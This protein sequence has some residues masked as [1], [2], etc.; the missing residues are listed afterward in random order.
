[1][2]PPPLL[3]LVERTALGVDPLAPLICLATENTRRRTVREV[4][5][6]GL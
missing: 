3:P 5:L 6:D 2:T 4:N 1:M